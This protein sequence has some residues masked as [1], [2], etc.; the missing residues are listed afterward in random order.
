M[1]ERSYRRPSCIFTGIQ[2]LLWARHQ[3]EAAD[4]AVRGAQGPASPPRGENKVQ[5]NVENSKLTPQP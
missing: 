4:A 2:S 3:L 1:L 5:A